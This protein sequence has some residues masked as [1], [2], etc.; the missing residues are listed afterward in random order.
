MT[1]NALNVQTKCADPL[2]SFS[3]TL[4]NSR[5]RLMY[6]RS[7]ETISL[8]TNNSFSRTLTFSR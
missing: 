5:S 2:Q 1:L 7:V 4:F 8:T 3:I 6:V